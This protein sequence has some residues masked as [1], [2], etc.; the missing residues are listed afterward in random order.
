MLNQKALKSYLALAKARREA[1]SP[2]GI[3]VEVSV[4]LADALSFLAVQ[5]DTY[6]GAAIIRAKDQIADP[7]LSDIVTLCVRFGSLLAPVRNLMMATSGFALNEIRTPIHDDAE[8]DR[9]RSMVGTCLWVCDKFHWPLSKTGAPLSP[10]M[11]INLRELHSPLMAEADFPA[12]LVQV[13]GDQITPVVRTIP[14]SEI[15]GSASDGSIPDWENEHLYYG[16][17]EEASGSAKDIQASSGQILYGEYIGIGPADSFAVSRDIFSFETVRY[18]IEIL[19]ENSQFSGQDAQTD[20]SELIDYLSD[21]F[22]AAMA[23]YEQSDRSVSD[24]DGYFFGDTKLRQSDYSS[25]FNDHG[26]WHGGGWKTLYQPCNKGDALPGL[27]IFWDGE[28][29][30]FWRI[31][32]GTF[33]FCAEADR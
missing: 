15:E 26:A 5:D 6:K 31:K 20:I 23:K 4:S 7:A 14:L 30:L 1:G 9:K 27:S 13:W 24:K 3:P 28:M 18:E 19:S 32:D 22:E 11:Q 25:W 2:S 29:A 17:T 21:R 12:L 16:V 10:L 33:E 8:V